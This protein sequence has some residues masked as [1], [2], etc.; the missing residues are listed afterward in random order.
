MSAYH[1]LTVRTLTVN[2]RYKDEEKGTLIKD[3][4][5]I[6]KQ[7][8]SLWFWI[9]LVAIL[10]SGLDLLGI[11]FD[12]DDLNKAKVHCQCTSALWRCRW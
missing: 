5:M 12:S 8:M 10:A 7:Y 2:A 11:I 1:I 3:Q 4:A 9:D 6:I